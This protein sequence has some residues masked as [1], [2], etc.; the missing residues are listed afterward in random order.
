MRHGLV[1]VASFLAC[2]CGSGTEDTAVDAGESGVCAA[3]ACELGVFFGDCGGSEEPVFACSERTGRCRWFVGGCPLDHRASDCGAEALCCESTEDGT[4]PFPSWEPDREL[5]AVQIALDVAA[6]GTDVLS[7]QSPRGLAVREDPTIAP[8]PGR[9]GVD[10]FPVTCS[11]GAPV[12]VCQDGQI[13]SVGRVAHVLALEVRVASRGPVAEELVV[14]VIP[15]AAGGAHARLYV[16]ETLDAI[17]TRSMACRPSTFLEVAGGEL[18]VNTLSP[19]SA[20]DLHGQ[21][22]ADLTSGHTLEFSF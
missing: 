15:G 6:L 4:W 17:P 5:A 10:P 3:E 7:E 11:A 2:G 22:R 12:Q 1:L 9:P 13:T 19:A 18:R 21:L 20:T 8:P 14:E 16:R